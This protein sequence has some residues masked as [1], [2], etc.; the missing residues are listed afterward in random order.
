[1][2]SLISLVNKLQRACTALGDHGEENALPTL[3][4]SLPA[5]AVVGGQVSTK[6]IP[7]LAFVWIVAFCA[8]R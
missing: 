8:T 7:D 1:M 2:E 6:H 3:W 4:D 5:I